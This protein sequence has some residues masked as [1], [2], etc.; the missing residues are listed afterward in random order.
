M[1][2]IKLK[3]CHEDTQTSASAPDLKCGCFLSSFRYWSFKCFQRFFNVTSARKKYFHVQ[4]DNINEYLATGTSFRAL[5]FSFRMG[6][7]TV[8]DI[9]YA[10]C[11][12][13]WQQ[14][15]EV[16]MARPTQEDFKNIA[17]DY[18]RLWQF[19]MCLGSID[20]K[21]CRMKCPAKSGSSFYNY[22]QYFSIILQGVADANKRFISIE[23]GGKNK[24][25]EGLF[26]IQR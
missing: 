26:I 13:I 16:H 21:H 2:I 23:V 17:N 8:A 9:V 19:P 5:A 18:Y 15:V 7:T 24:V 12:A 10:T 6:K 11:S 25:M 22:K 20:G 3:Y 4:I 14:L 1:N